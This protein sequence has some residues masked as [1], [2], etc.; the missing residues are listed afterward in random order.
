MLLLITAVDSKNVGAQVA[1]AS[2]AVS[3]NQVVLQMLQMFESP[4]YA[5]MTASIRHQCRLH[6]DTL[7]GKGEYW[8]QGAG[9]QR[10]SRFVMQ[11]QLEDKT[12]SYVQVFDGNY[13]WTD[14]SYPTGRKVRRL[15]VSRLKPRMASAG[16]GEYQQMLA[17]AAVRGGISQMLSDLLKRFD[18][19]S[20]RASQWNG[21]PALALIG[22]WRKSGLEELWPDYKKLIEAEEAPDWPAQLPHH[23]LLLV[24]PNN[25][26]PHVIEQRRFEDAYLATTVTGLRPTNDPLLRY[27]IFDVKIAVAIDPQKFVYKTGDVDWSDETAAVIERLGMKR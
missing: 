15:E 8:Q 10:L 3:G 22:H 20:P 18:F 19:D 16:Q 9:D 21:Q 23:V 27:E 6:D 13:L 7:V 11:T 24:G 1:P 17:E 25:L 5:S 12:A 2:G 14:R 4:Q 26:I